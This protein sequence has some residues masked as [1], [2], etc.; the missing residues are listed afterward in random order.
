M[1]MRQ[2][3]I[4]CMASST[5]GNPNTENEIGQC[6]DTRHT[7]LAR[8][9]TIFSPAGLSFQAGLTFFAGETTCSTIGFLHEK[10]WSSEDMTAQFL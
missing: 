3:Y 10:R 8:A 5:L 1:F 6:F 4:R 9:G 2:G 7:V